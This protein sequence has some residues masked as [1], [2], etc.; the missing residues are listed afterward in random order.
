GP[1][2]KF[3]GKQPAVMS[4]C[5]GESEQA[6]HRRADVSMIC[7]GVVIGSIFLYTRSYQAKPG[8][9]DL[10]LDPAMVPGESIG[11]GC[12]RHCDTRG[13]TVRC[14]CKEEVICLREH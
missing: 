12:G 3:L 10:R 8:R 13:R 1:A 7:P 5:I 14:C 11:R 2:L 9:G 6:Q 4:V